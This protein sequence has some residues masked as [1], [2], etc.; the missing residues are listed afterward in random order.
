MKHII[1]FAGR[2]EYL[3]FIRQIKHKY[4]QDKIFRHLRPI[5]IIYAIA[6]NDQHLKHFKHV[7]GISRVEKDCKI[8]VHFNKEKLSL[9]VTKP[10]RS[11]TTTSTITIPWGVKQLQAPKAWRWSKG[12]NVHIGVIDTGADYSHPDLQ[13]SL[14]QGY[15]CLYSYAPPDD[16]NGHGTHICGTIAAEGVKS[17][18]KGMAPKAIL[19]PVKA[20]DSQ[21]AAYV[22]DI[23]T[24]ID[25]CTANRVDII[26]MS[27][28]MQT[29]SQAL[30][31]AIKNASKKGIVIICSSGNEG[32]RNGIDFPARFTNTIS[33]GALNKKRTITKFSNRGKQV[34]VYAPGEKIYSTWLDGK[35]AILNG[36]S[37]ATSHVTG[38][39]AMLLALKPKLTTE[40]IRKI[41]K[42]SALPIIGKSGKPMSKKAVHAYRA[43][44][45]LKKKRHSS[46][47]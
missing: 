47:S 16:D 15:N 46:S 45:L 35:Y 20:F 38:I 39:A 42:Q 41:L 43:V 29:R 31:D 7:P 14:A 3:S 19:H 34:N 36:T 25:W 11:P 6:C 4:A 24:A 22:S 17:G 10:Y 44:S 21:G 40:E 18:I 33:V 27:F 1:R 8:R 12:R 37:M 9:P 32:K 13:F 2:H 26:N 23:I 30:L 5:N 28:G